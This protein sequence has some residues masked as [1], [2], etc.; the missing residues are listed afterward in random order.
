MF[1]LVG[2]LLSPAGE[3]GKLSILAYHRTLAAP[4]PILHDVID[5]AGFERHMA[6]LAEE[7]NVLRLREACELLAHGKLPARAA[8]ITFDDG[9]ADNEEIALP[10]LQR[11]RLPATFFVTTG[12]SN[13]TAM[14][15]D[16]I[17]EAVRR[18]PSG[19]HDLTGIG[20]GVHELGDSVTRRAAVEKL[21]AAV[22][23]RP[24]TE[25]RDLV[26]QVAGMFG[27]SLPHN[28]MM[29]PR[30]IARLHTEGMEIGAHTVN[31]PILKSI[32]EEEARAEIVS[33]KRTLEEIT[34]APVTSFAYPNGKPGRDYGPEHVR[35]VREAGFAA[36]VSAVGGI[37]DRRSDLFQLPRFSPW[38]RNPMK[39][40]ARL[41]LGCARTGVA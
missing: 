12:F 9:Y 41:L 14:F 39:L 2:D 18:A 19:T 32:R 16:G 29:T 11:L 27:S 3:R 28:L 6:L 34:G 15:N 5:A 23:Y 10:I 20:L 33:S 4:D 30:Q 35:L 17:I 36:A 38:E 37:A 40:G 24:I 1:H 25:R 13:G 22:K 8:C 7:F 26:Q 31:H 21:I